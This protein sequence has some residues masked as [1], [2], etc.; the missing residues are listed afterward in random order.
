[1]FYTKD[2][3]TPYIFDPFGFLGPKRR[4]M[5]ESSWAG[6]FREEILPE[7]PVRLLGE[8]YHPSQGRPTKELC[9]ML[10]AMILQQQFDL[11]DEETAE[12]FAF[13]IQWHYALNITGDGD[14][15]AY[16]CPKSIWS[17]RNTMTEHNLYTP[18]FEA[19][20]DK[21]SRILPVDTDKQRQDSMH[22][23]SNMRHLGRIGLFAKT[24]KK[25]LVNLK[26]HHKHEFSSLEDDLT[27]RYLSKAKEAVFS[28]VKPS[29]SKRTLQSL[30]DDLFS[31]VTRFKEHRQV[32]GMSSYSLLVRL[33][34]E[35]CTVEDD[36]DRGASKVTVKPNKEVPSDS[37]QNPS[38]PDAGYSGHK[39]QGY[40]VQVM[41]TYNADQDNNTLS[42]ITYVAVEPANKS[43]A[44]ALI[45]A[46]EDT[47]A[48]QLGPKEV[49]ADTTYG[50][51]ENCRQAEDLGVDIISPVGGKDSTG[52]LTLADFALS[53][54]G[55]VT[56]CPQGKSPIRC[57]HKK[58]RYSAAFAP[59][60]CGGC[61]RLSECPVRPGRKAYYLRYNDKAV[62]LAKRRA[63][64]QTPEFR[65]KY[66]YR[67]GIEGTL[68]YYARKTGVK[69]LRVRGQ[70]AVSFHAV[71]KATAINILRATAFRNRQT[72][73][74]NLP[75]TVNPVSYPACLPLFWII[76]E[77]LASLLDYYQKFFT[78]LR[79]KHQLAPVFA[80]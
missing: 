7:L 34:R 77:Q 50:S 61:S 10:G 75:E 49:Q 76:K 9:A 13:D 11:T 38:D 29:E 70:T 3:K 36:L 73:G 52:A 72:K 21:L 15:C 47:Q 16:V 63:Y 53:E 60:T 55:T 23:F 18:L 43:D 1:M 78:Q 65:D 33:M 17:M 48:R 58:N 69:R 31:L 35:Q 62:R 22:I 6:L 32:V 57:K 46:I 4:K 44:G 27:G 26:R 2:H 41:E 45:P 19:V 24:I 8:H 54:Q 67:A 25:F 42:L 64:E 56:A 68:S 39:G 79:T 80:I 40:Q 51:D 71:L 20:T 28:M 14:D 74:A 12:R 37:L 5:L 59:E 30:A 66:R